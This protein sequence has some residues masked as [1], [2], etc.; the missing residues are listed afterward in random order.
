MF[1]SYLHSEIF[2]WGCKSNGGQKPKGFY[3][4]VEPWNGT[5]LQCILGIGI[6]WLLSLS[7]ATSL[8]LFL[9]TG[10]SPVI[11]TRKEQM[12]KLIEARVTEIELHFESDLKTRKPELLYFKSLKP[13]LWNPFFLIPDL[14]L[15]GDLSRAA[16]HEINLN[17]KIYQIESQKF[18]ETNFLKTKSETIILA[19]LILKT[20]ILVYQGICLGQGWSGNKPKSTFASKLCF[21]T[22]QLG[23]S[24]S[25]YHYSL[26]NKLLRE[27]WKDC[28]TMMER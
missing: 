2:A 27:A 19:K 9:L 13:N 22:L 8:P 6:V 15:S 20:Q 24:I 23:T 28:L 5:L 16:C 21:P 18:D 7:S 14:S 10:G 4:I 17:R 12:W 26:G 1:W 25:T 11:Q 3:E